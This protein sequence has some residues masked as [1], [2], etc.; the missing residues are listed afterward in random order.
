MISPGAGIPVD[1]HLHPQAHRLSRYRPDRLL[2]WVEFAFGLGLAEIGFTDHDRFVG[3]I[4]F[5]V[6]TQLRESN[7][8]VK[9]RLGVELDNDPATS[10]AGREW[11][12]ANWGNLDYVLGAIH[13]LADGWGFDRPGA[14]MEFARRDLNRVWEDYFYQMRMLLLSGFVDA[15]AHFDLIKLFGH[16]LDPRPVAVVEEILQI[17]AANNIVLMIDTSGLRR[18]AKA[19]YPDDW[20]LAAAVRLGVSLSCGSNA[21]THPQ[22]AEGYDSLLKALRRNGIT[23]LTTFDRHT[24]IPVSGF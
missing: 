10:A 1:L 17:L 12:R 19:I 22:I 16:R 23:E 5:D 11:I 24:R 3:G 7:P 15:I 14:E 9:I 4:D 18:P 8:E 20:I 13:Y 6:I 21:H 2:D